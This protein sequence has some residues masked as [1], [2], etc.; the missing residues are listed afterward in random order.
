MSV[1]VFISLYYEPV[2][3]ILEVLLYVNRSKSLEKSSSINLNK[4]WVVVYEAGRYSG[5][6]IPMSAWYEMLAITFKQRLIILY[7][8]M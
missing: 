6:K 1:L 5:S 2:I 7:L 8:K 3:T 4:I